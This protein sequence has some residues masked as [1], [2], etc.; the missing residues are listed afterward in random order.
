M[1][2]HPEAAVDKLINGGFVSGQTHDS[3]TGLTLH[4][5]N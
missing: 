4:P 3:N 2:K 1:Q 5:N